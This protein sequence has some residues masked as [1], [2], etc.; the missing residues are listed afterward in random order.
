MEH[1]NVY[2]AKTRLSA[3]LQR[4]EAGEEFVIARAGS[5]VARLVP[6]DQALAPRQPGAWH[7]RVVMA[8]DFDATPA[9]VVAAFD[10]VP[11]TVATASTGAAT[12]PHSPDADSVASAPAT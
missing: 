8:P 2:E 3:L 1:V 11:P 4:V 6:Y 9:E 10:E 7:G 5:P 12:R